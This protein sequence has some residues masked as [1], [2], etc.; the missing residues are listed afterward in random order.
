MTN[1]L[2]VGNLPFAT[3]AQELEDLFSQA[4]SVAAVDL[5]YDKFTGRSRGFAFVS[6]ASAEDAPKAIER[7]NGFDLGGRSLTVSEA[8][9]KEP[10]SRTLT[11]AGGE[12]D[13]NNG[14]GRREHRNERDRRG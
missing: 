7:F 6:L 11:A 12:R 4:G 8:R 1:K 10:R 2:Y 14:F 5:I 9:P 3:T 13:F